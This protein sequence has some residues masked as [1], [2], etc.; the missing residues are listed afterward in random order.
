MRIGENP[1]LN[2]SSPFGNNPFRNGA[3]SVA[4]A[5]APPS[6]E[7]KTGRAVFSE[8][9]EDYAVRISAEARAAYESH[10][11]GQKKTDQGDDA[12]DDFLRYMETARSAPKDIKERIKEQKA[13]LDKL[14]AELQ[15]TASDESLPEEVKKPRITAL[16]SQIQEAMKTIADLSKQLAG[17]SEPAEASLV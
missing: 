3:V 10:A 17:D 6:G 12:R 15:K 1:Y 2:Q 8:K 16:S 5:P 13:K 14:Q 4:E 9:S 7:S 11:M